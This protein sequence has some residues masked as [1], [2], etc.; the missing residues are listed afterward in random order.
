MQTMTGFCKRLANRFVIGGLVCLF[1]LLSL[2]LS[3]IESAPPSTWVN[4]GMP[5]MTL[6]AQ[7]E[8]ALPPTCTPTS[9]T[10][11]SYTN[12]N[13]SFNG[14]GREAQTAV[15]TSQN[16]LGS[17]GSDAGVTTPS[18]YGF[19]RP[20][21]A[22]AFRVVD[23]LGRRSGILP[24]P[25]QAS[26]IYRQSDG[27][28]YGGTSLR[29]YDSFVGAGEFK[30][31]LG[32]VNELAF[33]LKEPFAQPL[34]DAN[35]TIIHLK[36]AYAFSPNGEWM[37]IEAESLG[38]LRINT[39]TRE[40]RLISGDRYSYGTGFSIGYRLAISNDGNYASSTA[41]D[42]NVW[43]Y[44]LR[45]CQAAPFVVGANNQIAAGCQRREVRQSI[46]DQIGQFR[47]LNQM[48]FSTDGQSIT[49]KVVRVEGGATKLYKFTYAVAGYVPPVPLAYLA[50]GD[51]FSSGE[52]IYDYAYG[53][54]TNNP[55]NQCHLS[56]KS[57]PYLAARELGI[58][59]SSHNVA[60]SGAV[61][62]DYHKKQDNQNPV[63]DSPL[64]EWLP[65][66]R[67]QVEYISNIDDVGVVTIS[68]FGNDIEFANK[69]KRCLGPDTCFQLKEERQAIAYNI[70]S[71]FD[72]LVELYQDIKQNSG[73]GKLYVM[74]YPQLFGVADVCKFNVGLDRQERVMAKNLT[75]Y[76]NAFIKSATEKAG[77]VYI[78]AEHAFT[79]RQ[80]CDFGSGEKAV[81]GFT[82]GVES[83]H[84]NKLGHQLMSEQLLLQSQN[85]TKPMPI[86]DSA[87]KPSYIG[88]GV[89]D[90]LIGD[91]P[92][93]GVFTRA[94]YSDMAGDLL[95]G[96][97]SA[98]VEVVNMPL[99]S[100]TTFQIWFNSEPT[101][102]GTLATDIQGNL[103][104]EITVPSSLSPGYHTMHL[105][106]QNIAGEEIDLYKTIYVAA[107][108]AD[109]DGDGI[110]ND[111]EKC[112]GVEPANVDEDRDGV[113]DACDAEITDP[114]ADS[115]S[116]AVTG[117]PDRQANETGWYNADV[118]INWSAVD[119]DPS[120]GVPT[121]PTATIAS[122][123]GV[124]TYS[125]GPSCDPLN[126]CATGQLELKI[127]KTAPDINYS[128]SPA[129]NAF[130]WNS[131]TV[132]VT[133]TCSD[134]ISGVADCTEPQI[135]SG[136]D[137]TYVVTGYVTD[138]AGNTSAVNAFVSLDGTKPTVTQSVLPAPNA[139]GWV[140]TDVMITPTCGDNLSG[141]S[142]C[143]P[144][145]TLST[146]G[147]NQ[148]VVSTAT[149]SAGNTATTSRDIN[150]DKT[151]PALGA[152]SWS[153]NPKS[154]MGT[155][156]ITIPA[157]D[158]LSGIVEAE[159]FLG[160]LD[161][162]R[163][164]GATMQIGEDAISV[165]FAADFPTGVYKVT[166]R[167]KD[168]AGNWSAGVSDYLVVYDPL[169]TRMTGKRTLLPSLA[170]GD[171]LPGLIANNQDDKAKFG[172][173]VRYDKDGKIHHN[174]DFQFKYETGAKCNK[175]AQA[176]N[177]HNLE[178][179]ATSIAWL[180]T[181]GQD[182]STGI[183]QGMAKLEADGVI[184]NAVFRLVGVDGELL[185]STSEDR[186]TL[187]IYPEN[188]NPNT[189]TPTYQ[190]SSD[191]LRGNIK[192]R[193]W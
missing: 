176:I 36:D 107:S 173:N 22:N 112:L 29:F 79:E 167:A 104:G 175:S 27:S 8:G 120:S 179:N 177:C 124:H 103:S 131:N 151:A 60:C 82:G 74:G 54:D 15:C 138:N 61:M 37:L 158:S 44:D 181:Q 148:A 143:S 65:G 133:F 45:D 169:G 110:L 55:R 13:G 31:V 182:D 57:Y 81:N 161:P 69:I 193:K 135:V 47:E 53:T 191:V 7:T 137:S 58:S 108:E 114:P 140:N 163:G 146:E 172:F 71:K 122:Q 49:G 30:Q 72:E 68:M 3:T 123:E 77:A 56:T 70:N 192:I 88:S 89:Y 150:I 147:A 98:A 125:S 101:F 157:T 48:R 168:K 38:F 159:Y 130:G 178:L 134:A 183:F 46:V 19:I 174:S 52:G 171:I 132:T 187:K 67:A 4:G 34:R 11:Y 84:P 2:Q 165:G 41:A 105:Y 144:S 25:G 80:L 40:M 87:K 99:R 17:F 127:D 75:T 160:D 96:G 170:G 51:S 154:V 145:I 153:N 16:S 91:A 18:S 166:V 126:N 106:G 164:N 76:L 162:G 149:D 97:A 119:P 5:Q 185:D 116:P 115:T 113:D 66:Y 12:P 10:Y 24:V 118:T 85:F 93:G 152:A 121:R 156:A 42:R 180:T 35:G 1:T 9:F 184:S 86:P 39:K 73:G 95:Y 141:I 21:T 142:M 92:G 129:P 117:T 139:S 78:D 50:L 26:Y 100:M 59:T 109:I 190:V 6:G 64:Q 155:A 43:V 111:D 62:G 188:A 20:H 14:L 136:G 102:A 32:N 63:A 33:Q 90:N 83:F 28:I 186:V 189:A 23:S 94:T 128:L